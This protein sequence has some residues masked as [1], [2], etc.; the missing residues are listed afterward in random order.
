[1]Q[2]FVIIVHREE[3]SGWF[4]DFDE[5]GV[6]VLSTAKA[7]GV[8]Y[9]K[10]TAVALVDALGARGYNAVLEPAE[11]AATVTKCDVAIHENPTGEDADDS[12]KYW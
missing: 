2:L 5:Y 1:M 3:R 9:T 10:G 7:W 11:D 8:R 12:R 6:P 4:R